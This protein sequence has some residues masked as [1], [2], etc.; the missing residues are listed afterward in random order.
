MFSNIFQV[1]TL[2]VWF[3]YSMGLTHQKTFKSLWIYIHQNHCKLNGNMYLINSSGELRELIKN[4]IK[5]PG[6]MQHF[7]FA[8]IKGP[9]KK[10]NIWDLSDKSMRAAKQIE[11]WWRDDDWWEWKTLFKPLPPFYL[12]SGISPQIK[13]MVSNFNIFSKASL[14]LIFWTLIQ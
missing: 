2:D 9:D 11:I 1:Q 6:P 8:S 10:L 5:W 12:E 13:K 7:A 3:H 4:K 14:W